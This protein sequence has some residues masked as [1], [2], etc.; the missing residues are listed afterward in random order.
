MNAV[1]LHIDRTRTNGVCVCVEY[2][3]AGRMRP[4]FISCRLA[5]A[6]QDAM[7]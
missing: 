6:R 7:S 5:A 1:S 4:R 2:V 3:G